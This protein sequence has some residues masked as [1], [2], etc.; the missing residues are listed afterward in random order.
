M[1]SGGIASG[2]WKRSVPVLLLSVLLSSCA[3]SY[4]PARNDRDTGYSESQIAP[5]QFRVT[6]QGN[7]DTPLERAC[8][9]V[10]LRCAEVTRQHGFVC[11]EVLDSINTSS[12]KN[13]KIARTDSVPVADSNLRPAP[14][15]PAYAASNDRFLPGVQSTH[16]ET[17]VYF[18]PGTSLVIKCFS[19]KPK[20]PF[21]FD[22]TELTLQM[23]QRYRL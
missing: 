2:E 18:K 23:K 21:T 12:A 15:F 11:F 22:A 9:F 6:F 7:A 1:K 3:T 5:D 4:R 14:G 20:K 8:D 13:Y 17:W 19:S 16:E 10:L